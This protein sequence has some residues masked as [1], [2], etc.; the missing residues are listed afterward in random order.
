M[1]TNQIEGTARN[2]GGKIQDAAGGL[3]GD[4]ATQARGKLNQMAG[5]A[6]S[7]FGDAADQARELGD[8]LVDGV[9]SQPWVA[10]AA[11]G[12]VGF[13]LGMLARR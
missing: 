13:A 7:T 8:Q 1:D 4:A 11:V 3:T 2:I 6:Q 12:A 5:K 10:L 9:R